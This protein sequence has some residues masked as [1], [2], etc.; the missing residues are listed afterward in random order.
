MDDSAL[1]RQLGQLVKER[2][3]ALRL[4]QQDLSAT[5][6]VSRA[7]VANME[8]GR[9]RV[10][11]HYLYRIAE[12]LKMEV[13]ELLPKLGRSER[14]EIQSSVSLSSDQRNLVEQIV[15]SVSSVNRG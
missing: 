6:G 5:I 10:S 3:E 12:T 8:T 14:V 7:W 4:S 11:V 1:Y 13:H 2:R 9:Q 15:H